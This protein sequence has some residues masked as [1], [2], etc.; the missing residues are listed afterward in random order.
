MTSMALTL[1]HANFVTLGMIIAMI[2]LI[3]TNRIFERRTNLHFLAFIFLIFCL[4]LADMTDYYLAVKSTPNF[5]RYLAIGLGYTI[6]PATIAVIIAI[7]LR[8]KK[9]T[10]LLFIPVAV[11]A[12]LALSSYWTHFVFYLNSNNAFVRG[13]C[14]F[15]SHI[16]SALF[17]LL[18]VTVSIKNY[19]W[20]D[21][22]ETLI[23]IY[24]AIFS[25]IATAIENIYGVKF[26]LP[27]AMITSCALYYIYLFSQIYKRDQLTNLLNRR[28]FFQTAALWKEENLAVISIDLNNLKILNDEQGHKE[29]D[30]ALKVLAEILVET[31]K[32]R[33]RVY[34][35]GGDE[36]MVLGKHRT[37]TE[38][39]LYIEDVK[40]VLKSTP[41]MA[42]FGCAMY[43]PKDNFDDICNQADTIMYTDKSQY[44]H[45]STPRH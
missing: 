36:F 43:T 30:I 5:L 25:T 6:R 20:H 17:M 7:I 10:H 22:G 4:T 32:G 38:A 12:F 45:R 27:G 15:S 2:V 14:G 42:S 3:Y 28:N 24:I 18:L 16:I 9:E 26:V 8:G 31:A 11:N 34:R 23:V 37:K 29:G 35:I 19:K 1:I 33:F 39:D 21:L 44:R 41:Y 40:G 13:P